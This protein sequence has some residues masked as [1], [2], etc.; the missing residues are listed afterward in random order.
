MISRR[1]RRDRPQFGAGVPAYRPA[2][3]TATATQSFAPGRWQD[4]IDVRDFVQR[5]YEPYEGDAAFL[6]GPTTGRRP[7]GT[8]SP[9]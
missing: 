3:M 8:S 1:N 2:E 4:E 5:N 7:S 9:P 6:A